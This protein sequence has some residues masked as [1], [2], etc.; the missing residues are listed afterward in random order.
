[1]IDKY[2]L[3]TSEQCSLCYKAEDI[4][5]SLSIVFEKVDIF[6]DATLLANYGS[7]IPVLALGNKVVVWPFTSQDVQGLKPSSP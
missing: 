7:Y 2:I 1:M 5:K 6:Q 3:Y 4:L